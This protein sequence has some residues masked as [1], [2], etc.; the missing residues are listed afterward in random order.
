MKKSDRV[1]LLVGIF[2][3][4]IALSHP[5]LKA[6]LDSRLS[7]KRL[8]RINGR[9]VELEEV[10]VRLPELVEEEAKVD[11]NTAKAERLSELPGVGP[12]LAKRIVTY[13]EKEGNF[14]KI[15]QLEKVSGIGS[16]TLNRFQDR[17]KVGD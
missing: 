17:V 16:E 2:L 15:E 13:R 9:A 5:Y 4:C 10:E 3:G 14:T 11:L 8:E 6:F 1:I 12:V 7:G